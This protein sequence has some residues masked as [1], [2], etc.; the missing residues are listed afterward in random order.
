[1]EGQVF[2]PVSLKISKRTRFRLHF[3]KSHFGRNAE[4]NITS[5]IEMK[6]LK[7]EMYITHTWL[8]KDG[9]LIR[10]E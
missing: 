7:G 6:M 8:F 2:E 10:E 3:A 5:V 1:M 4:G 9:K